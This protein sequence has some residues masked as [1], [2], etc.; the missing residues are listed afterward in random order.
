MVSIDM[1]NRYEKFFGSR[2]DV[3]LTVTDAM[4]QDLQ[5]WPAT[6]P[7]VTL[8]DRPT[9]L[10]RKLSTQEKLSELSFLKFPSS[11]SPVVQVSVSPN[12]VMCDHPL[13]SFDEQ[14][15]PT[16]KNNRPILIVS[17][18]S[19][20]ADEDFSIL[21]DALKSYDE[22]DPERKICII[23]TGKGPMKDHYI[24]MYKGLELKYVNLFTA[25]LP[26][27]TYPSIL[28]CADIG[29]S[30]HTSSSGLDLPMKIVDMFGARVPVLALK[31]DW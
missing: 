22:S 16:F 31:F 2:A 30:L 13:L 21:L 12:A 24:G 27:E 11:S 10:F 19:W 3:H 29:I 9:N 17:S 26:V 1:I 14:K 7:V 6:G 23:I 5:S 8:Y 25:W 15:T 20:T 4:A 18:T 28:G